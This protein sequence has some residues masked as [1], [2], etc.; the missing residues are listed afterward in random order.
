MFSHIPQAMTDRMHTLE[1]RDRR[2]R[3]MK[4]SEIAFCFLD[5]E[6]EVYADCYE[7]VI[8]NMVTGG[9]LA[10]DNAINHR[11]T[12]QPM[13]D[14]ALTDDRVDGLIVPIGKGVLVSRR[15]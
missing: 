4:I 5:A 12:L 8:P 3:L 9:I 2:D 13:L 6:K 7:A 15:R 11:E 14:R 1:E 10:A